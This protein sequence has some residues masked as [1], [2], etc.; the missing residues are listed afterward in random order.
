[1]FLVEPVS[2]DVTIRRF[3]C[4]QEPPS[5]LVEFDGSSN[6][7]SCSIAVTML[8]LSYFAITPSSNPGD[9]DYLFRFLQ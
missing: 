6:V 5:A 4:N 1:M 8:A 2:V 3:S 9:S 7:V